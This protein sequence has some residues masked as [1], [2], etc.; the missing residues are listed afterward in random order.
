M[1]IFLLSP[2]P[3][4]VETLNNF[5]NQVNEVKWM[6]DNPNLLYFIVNYTA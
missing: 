3:D 4:S 6:A 5:F 1:S 2:L